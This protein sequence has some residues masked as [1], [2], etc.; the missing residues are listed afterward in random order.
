MV[1]GELGGKG[2]LTS[3][4]TQVFSTLVDRNPPIFEHLEA[5]R[6]QAPLPGLSPSFLNTG[7][8]TQL[9]SS[10]APFPPSDDFSSQGLPITSHQSQS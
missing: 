6:A 10:V 1:N 2:Q 5:R 9:R 7:Y 8:A 4:T 3:W